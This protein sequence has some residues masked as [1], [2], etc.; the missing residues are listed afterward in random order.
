MR[1]PPIPIEAVVLA[2]KTERA[3]RR[4]V[5]TIPAWRFDRRQF[6]EVEIDD[7]LKRLRR[8]GASQALGQCIEPRRIGLLKIEQFGDRVVPSPRP[9]AT[10]R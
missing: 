3:V 1:C 2:Q 9:G 10:N 5:A 4:S 7:G 6:T 8:R